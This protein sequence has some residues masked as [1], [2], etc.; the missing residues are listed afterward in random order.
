[1][2]VYNEKILQMA[3]VIE[4]RFAHTDFDGFL[5]R[6]QN[7]LTADFVWDS[8]V[9]YMTGAVWQVSTLQFPDD[10]RNWANPPGLL[11]SGNLT[12]EE[13]A[14][15][16][17]LA[18]YLPPLAEVNAYWSQTRPYLLLRKDLLEALKAP[19]VEQIPK[20]G[21]SYPEL[22]Q[23]YQNALTKIDQE[24]A[25]IDQ[26]LSPQGSIAGMA[27]LISPEIAS[28]LISTSESY[29]NPSGSNVSSAGLTSRSGIQ[30]QLRTQAVD[31]SSGRQISRGETVISGATAGLSREIRLAQKRDAIKKLLPQ[32]HYVY[33]VRVVPLNASGGCAGLPSDALRVV[34]GEKLED[35]VVLSTTKNT[36][37]KI[38]MSG[39]TGGEFDFW[40]TGETFSNETSGRWGIDWNKQVKQRR[41]TPLQAAGYR[42]LKLPSTRQCCS[43]RCL[44]GGV[45]SKQPT[46]R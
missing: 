42:F 40:V 12:G 24:I 3:H 39:G 6:S 1:M 35:N 25:Q 19:L 15:S 22:A 18:Q 37:L 34:I 27:A 13:K 10:T 21:P 17:D 8:Q 9:R 45:Q 4:L 38:S 5:N 31:D 7:D 33:Y 41:H 14:F 32:T 23:E 36:D 11:D 16:V 26:T 28:D 30:S 20:T 46:H 2:S 44:V 29:T 43:T